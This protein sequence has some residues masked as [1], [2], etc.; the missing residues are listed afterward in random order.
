MQSS[1]SRYLPLLFYNNYL[2]AHAYI[3]NLILKK[4][5]ELLSLGWFVIVH[6]PYYQ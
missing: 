6:M 5:L 4:L 3:E 2:T 1:S